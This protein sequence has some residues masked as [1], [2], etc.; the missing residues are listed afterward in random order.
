MQG[1][2]RRLHL[3]LLGLLLATTAWSGDCPPSDACLQGPILAAV[4]S[5][6]VRASPCGDST[7]PSRYLIDHLAFED[8]WACIAGTARY[9]CRSCP[10]EVKFIALLKWKCGC[11]QVSAISF[12]AGHVTRRQ[13]IG[14]RRVP[15]AIL[16]R[17]VRWSD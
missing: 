3:A 7:G 5:E 16:P 15:S 2:T 10:F 14:H 4:N 12:D 13:F 9:Q 1:M 17:W 6:F 11:W 8:E